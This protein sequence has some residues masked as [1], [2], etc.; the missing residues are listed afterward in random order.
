MSTT[1][2]TAYIATRTTLQLYRD[3]LRLARHAGQYNNNEWTLRTLVTSQFREHRL[4]TDP[5]KIKELR[6][7]AV[8]AISNYM[9]LQA[10]EMVEKDKKN[11][12]K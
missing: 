2:P 3:L 10:V 12:K 11:T 1:S 9:V 7:S 8:R 4:E 5:E 6:E